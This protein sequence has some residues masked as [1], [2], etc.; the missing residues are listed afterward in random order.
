MKELEEDPPSI[1]RRPREPIISSKDFVE[2]GKSFKKPPVPRASSKRA[3]KQPD[4]R[5]ILK[6]NPE[7]D[8]KD[9]EKLQRMILQKSR[10]ENLNADDLQ[11]ALALSRSLGEQN[12]SSPNK[13]A[14]EF[15]EMM[16]MA[17]KPRKRTRKGNKTTLLTRRDP[18]RE[19]EK[20]AGRIE[21]IV[22]STCPAQEG[23]SGCLAHPFPICSCYLFDIR[24]DG[25]DQ[26][27]MQVNCQAQEANRYYIKT[28]LFPE[29]SLAAGH[30][31]R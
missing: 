9:E 18:G 5:K 19:S 20:I 13:K 14:V 7:L 28:N 3:K 10:E 26:R 6:I 15:F 16:G 2:A 27:I 29:S 22:S 12:R 17:T 24:V 8:F 30:L 1:N 11:I 4:I 25:A 23:A 21:E 31:L